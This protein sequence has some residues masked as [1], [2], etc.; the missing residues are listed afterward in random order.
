MKILLTF[1]FLFATVHPGNT[2]LF[3]AIQ[4]DAYTASGNLRPYI[5]PTEKKQDTKAPRGYKPFYFSY[6]GRHGSRHLTGDVS[7]ISNYVCMLDSLNAEGTLTDDGR[8]LLKQ[9]RRLEEEHTGNSG[10]LTATG[11]NEERAISARLHKRFHKVFRQNSRKKVIVRTSPSLRS[12]MTGT[13]FI[14]ELVRHNPK[15]EFDVKGGPRYYFTKWDPNPELD[16][17]EI[18]VLDSMIKVTFDTAA[19]CR[20]FFLDEPGLRKVL[21][22]KSIGKAQYEIMHILSIGLCISPDA[23][24]FG[25]FSP[26]ELFDYA[27]VQNART[28]SWFIH[29][30]E[31]GFYRDTNAGA[32]LIND[33]VCRAQEAIEGNGIC[34]DLRFGHDS[35]VAPAFSFLQIDGYDN[36]GASL[37]DTWKTWPAYKHV[38]MACN[39]SVILYRN[40]K[41]D[42]LV[43]ILENERETTIPAVSPFSGPYYKWKDFED[44]C[45]RRI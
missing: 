27:V 21:A 6:Y 43:K 17:T 42:I 14:M 34:A 2:E 39:L 13:S 28:A 23:D 22:G 26:E 25:L 16:A 15:L 4:Q 7:F 20:R 40:R 32:P 41:G 44:W 3:R 19:F 24:S 29:S 10:I 5:A 1:L 11:F 12:A 38:T 45:T 31:T 33:I 18:R 35:G 9:L 37:A 8:E 30:K 36:P